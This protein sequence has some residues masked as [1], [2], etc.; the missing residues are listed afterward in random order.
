MQKYE[1]PSNASP[2]RKKWFQ[3]KSRLRIL[4]AT[5]DMERI[6]LDVVLR[7]LVER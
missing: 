1:L 5:K 7:E 3:R 2:T 6:G 4:K